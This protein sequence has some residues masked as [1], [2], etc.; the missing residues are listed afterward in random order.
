L[1]LLQR[2]HGVGC[3]GKPC[4]CDCPSQLRKIP[5][6]NFQTLKTIENSVN[7]HLSAIKHYKEIWRV[8]DRTR[9]GRLKCVRAEAAIKTVRE[10]IRRN[11]LW[12]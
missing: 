9:S 10:R 4:G 7:L 11:P 1:R 6:S 3:Q 12:K 5:F 2:E 8:E